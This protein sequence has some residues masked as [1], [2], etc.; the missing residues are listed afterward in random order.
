M[1]D[2]VSN[3]LL[4]QRRQAPPMI[5]KAVGCDFIANAVPS[6]PLAVAAMSLEPVMIVA[7]IAFGPNK[8]SDQFERNRR[9]GLQFLEALKRSVGAADLAQPHRRSEQKIDDRHAV[10]EANGIVAHNEH[11]G[12]LAFHA[13]TLKCASSMPDISRYRRQTKRERAE[14]DNLIASFVALAVP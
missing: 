13:R 8:P 1:K 5:Q 9:H 12:N 11:I 10:S 4:L 3:A 7:L 6:K 2:Q 14:T